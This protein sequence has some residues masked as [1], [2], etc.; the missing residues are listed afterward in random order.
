MLEASTDMELVLRATPIDPSSHPITLMPGFNWIGYPL[1]QPMSIDQA[2]SGLV[3]NNG[4]FI[5]SM[6]GISMYSDGN[7]IGTFTTF[8]PG[9]GYIYKST[10]T[11]SKSFCFP[12]VSKKNKEVLMY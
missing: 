10:A 3:P 2:L 7:W 11:E 8:E 1:A 9:Q 12:V 4:D 6:T 5:K